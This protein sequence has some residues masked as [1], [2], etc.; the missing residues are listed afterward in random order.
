MATRRYVATNGARSGRVRS[1]CY[2]TAGSG[3]TLVIDKSG[4][5]VRCEMN[6]GQI[7]SRSEKNGELVRDFGETEVHDDQD[8]Y[9]FDSEFGMAQLGRSLEDRFGLPRSRTPE[10][11]MAEP[12]RPGQLKG[13]VV[14]LDGQPIAGA[15]IFELPAQTHRHTA[16][17]D[18]GEFVFSVEE[19][20]QTGHPPEPR[21]FGVRH[22]MHSIYGFRMSI[23]FRGVTR[24]S[25]S[26]SVDPSGAARGPLKMSPGVVVPGRVLRN[27]KPVAGVPIGLKQIGPD[28]NSPFSETTGGEHRRQRNTSVSLILSPETEFWVHAKLRDLG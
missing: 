13:K 3:E 25:E 5:F 14:D 12:P 23:G 15:K 20:R 8:D 10:A 1:R 28:G 27:G 2:E 24:P 22:Q 6:S 11:E 17:T 26:V 4:K 7:I 16:T 18:S 21:S 19:R 9:D